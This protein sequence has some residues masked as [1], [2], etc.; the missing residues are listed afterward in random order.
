MRPIK[1]VRAEIQ[2]S[3]KL[4]WKLASKDD[5]DEMATND[6]LVD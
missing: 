1:N 4:A 2:A 3:D 6:T 5:A